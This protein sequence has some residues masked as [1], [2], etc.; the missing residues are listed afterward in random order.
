VTLTLVPGLV[1]DALS[2]V[3][4]AAL[5]AAVLKIAPRR[6]A[7]LALAVFCVGYGSYYIA[8]NARL[9]LSADDPARPL[10]TDLYLASGVASMLALLAL[11]GLFPRP[12]PRREAWLFVPGIVLVAASYAGVAASAALRGTFDP[13]R[14]MVA[15]VGSPGLGFLLGG[16][17]LLIALRA[18]RTRWTG[19]LLRQAAIISAA[20]LLLPAFNAGRNLLLVPGADAGALLARGMEWVTATGLVVL[21]LMMGARNRG[22]DGRL[23]RNVALLVPAMML[24]GLLMARVDAAGESGVFGLV[25]LVMAALLVYAILRHQL[26][27]LDVKVKWTLR[28]STVAAAFIGVFFVVSESASTF[29]ATSGLGSYLGIAAAGLLVFAMAPLQRAAERVANAAMPGV[30]PATAMARP[31]REACYKNQAAA[32]WADGTLSE[33]ERE[34]LDAAREY[35]GLSAEEASALE[36]EARLEAR[37]ARA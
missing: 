3:C 17:L 32:A 12:L 16:T 28:Q 22:P 20:I 21:W 10:V 6:P 4:I 36:R 35:L 24:L 27:G 11:G 25:R 33:D 29:F 5:G 13:I 26:L 37:G 2:A 9:M 34:M 30:R 19:A 7:N 8:G 31:E 15:A 18:L 23:A 1:L 14:L